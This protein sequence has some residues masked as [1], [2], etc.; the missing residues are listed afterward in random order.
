[1]CLAAKAL[2]FKC[3][4]KREAGN[5]N[6]KKIKINVLEFSKLVL[7]GLKL[8]EVKG[9]VMQCGQCHWWLWAC[10]Q[11]GTS[12]GDGALELPSHGLQSKPLAQV[13]GKGKIIPLLLWCRSFFSQLLKNTAGLVLSHCWLREFSL[14]QARLQPIFVFI[15]HFHLESP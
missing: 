3:S 2:G 4:A 1:M 12:E 11:K 7:I 6:L 10:T 13:C 8:T 5:S 9:K 15:W 14:H